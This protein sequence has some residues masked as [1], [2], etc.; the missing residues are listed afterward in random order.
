M[1]EIVSPVA[2][3]FVQIQKIVREISEITNAKIKADLSL[4]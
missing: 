1:A 3:G 2:K 4:T